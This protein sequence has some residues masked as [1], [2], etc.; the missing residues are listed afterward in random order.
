[1]HLD[2]RPENRAYIDNITRLYTIGKIN[3]FATASN[4]IKKLASNDKRTYNNPNLYNNYKKLVNTLEPPEI[5]R[6]K[7]RKP[8]LNRPSTSI[9]INLETLQKDDQG[10]ETYSWEEIFHYIEN[11]IKSEIR[12]V[13]ATKKPIK[14]R[15]RLNLDFVKYQDSFDDERIENIQNSNLST[16][17]SNMLSNADD[18]HAILEEQKK[19]IADKLEVFKELKGSGWTIKTYHY[20]AIDIYE[21]KKL[22]GSSYIPTPEKY[23]N[24]KCGL[25]NIKMMIMS[26]SDG[27]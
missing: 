12:E 6:I 25:V 11:K 16:H 7:I 2:S 9:I 22:R 19:A 17:A 21:I 15:L 8:D 13:L 20:L 3:N 27:V 24:A 4:L 23:K 1:L 5:V 10:H 26:A 18:I 14:I